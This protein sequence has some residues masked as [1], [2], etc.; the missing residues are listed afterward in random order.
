MTQEQLWTGLADEGKVGK[1][2]ARNVATDFVWRRCN[3][4]GGN[5]WKLTYW[6]CPRAEGV[7]ITSASYCQFPELAL[8][9]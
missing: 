8:L 4:F 7:R 3:D 6:F 5:S 9:P 1:E 2:K